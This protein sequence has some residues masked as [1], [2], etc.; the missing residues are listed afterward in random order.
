MWPFPCAW[1]LCVLLSGWAACSTPHCVLCLTVCRALLSEETGVMTTEVDAALFARATALTQRSPR[2]LHR[3][4][5][6]H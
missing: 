2:E 1:R 3:F 6:R 5:Y 4:A